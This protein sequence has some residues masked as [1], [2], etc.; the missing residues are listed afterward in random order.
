MPR[1]FDESNARINLPRV[2]TGPPIANQGGGAP[3]IARPPAAP[4]GV[5]P[6]RRRDE[7]VRPV[8]GPQTLVPQAPSQTQPLAPPTAPGLTPAPG[9]PAVTQP[10]PP[11]GPMAAPGPVPTK[12]EFAGMSGEKITVQSPTGLPPET[13]S[14]DAQ[15]AQIREQ[16]TSL[17]PATATQ[18]PPPAKT[19]PLGDQSPVEQFTRQRTDLPAGTNHHLRALAIP[20]T[21]MTPEE[22]MRFEQTAVKDFQKFGRYSGDD[23]P[24]APAPPIRP[25]RQSFNPTTGQWIRPEGSVSVID[26]VMRFGR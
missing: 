1:A 5:Q 7:L 4:T 23:D 3:G 25:G 18:E 14:P 11:G 10:T 15:A 20:D 2:P 19:S 17:S 24:E 6:R 8:S 21:S 9:A 16:G 12:R 22:R 13:P 26:K